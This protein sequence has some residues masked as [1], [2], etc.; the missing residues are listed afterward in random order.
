MRNYAGFELE[1]SRDAH[2]RYGAR[3]VSLVDLAPGLMADHDK[4]AYL[5]HVATRQ[6]FPLQAFLGAERVLQNSNGS[7]PYMPGYDGPA[8]V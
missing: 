7:F 4:Q 6:P 1:D 8:Q 2:A 3:S 5:K